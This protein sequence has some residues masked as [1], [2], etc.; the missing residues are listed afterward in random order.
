MPLFHSDR[1][2][3][4]DGAPLSRVRSSPA[5]SGYSGHFEE[6]GRFK[7]WF[8]K[9]SHKLTH[10][11]SSS[12]SDA[13]GA[14]R[15]SS[16][17]G[18]VPLARVRA[19]A[20]G[21][22]SAGS[23]DETYA[24]KM[25]SESN[26]KD[27]YS[28]KTRTARIDRN[29]LHVAFASS[30]F[31]EDPPQQIPPVHAAKGNVEFKNGELLL[32]PRPHQRS[33]F[34]S[35]PYLER[36]HEDLAVIAQ[37]RARENAI[38]LHQ[39]MT[40]R[41]SMGLFHSASD[42]AL[43]GME[44]ESYGEEALSK[45]EVNGANLASEVS[46][47]HASRRSSEVQGQAGIS[48]Q[49]DEKE[50]F[51][52]SH[53]RKAKDN[54]EVIYTRCCHL[55][56]IMPIK[57][58]IRQLKGQVAP[59]PRL[60]IINF[61]PALIEV[62]ALADFLAIVPVVYLNLDAHIF[63][64]EMVR[65]LCAALYNS[66]YMARLSFCNTELDPDAWRHLCSFLAGNKSLLHLDLSCDPSKKSKVK[67][68]S[69]AKND[70][71]AFRKAL[72]KR[73]GLDELTLDYTGIRGKDILAL[74]SEGLKNCKVLGLAHNNL[75]PSEISSVVDWV[76]HENSEC[77]GISLDGNDLS[78]SSDDVTRLFKTPRLYSISLRNTNLVVTEGID[79]ASAIKVADTSKLR[80]L[81][82]SGNREVLA[83][84]LPHLVNMLPHYK[85]LARLLLDDCNLSSD[86]I[87]LLCESVSR[88]PRLVYLSLQ[89]KSR[90]SEMACAALCVAVHSRGTIV[91]VD[92]DTSY[93]PEVYRRRLNEYLMQNLSQRKTFDDDIEIA[94]MNTR[95]IYKEIEQVTRE[96][97]TGEDN[98]VTEDVL[99][100]I[101]D[102]R[103]RVRRGLHELIAKKTNGTLAIEDRE[104][105][106]KLFYIDGSLD[107]L[108]QQCVSNAGPGTRLPLNALPT[109]LTEEK[110]SKVD[111]G[112]IRPSMSR[113]S[114][115]QSI[116]SLKKQ[117]QG[118][119]V[120]HKLYTHLCDLSCDSE[121]NKQLAKLL[122]ME[123][124]AEDLSHEELI[125]RIRQLHARD[126]K[127]IVD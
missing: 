108:F 58:I 34:V 65:L 23:A 122:S 52:P 113:M 12:G 33:N 6:Q 87:V 37:Q 99:E 89:S 90:F 17:E 83:E 100:R 49:R 24:R 5:A 127:Q 3:N 78:K 76:C 51:E 9:L 68:F 105:L 72:V 59:V 40:S 71:R 26:S 28:S 86:S 93:W 43:L 61:R 96:I 22:F 77:I 8:G 126:L 116:M 98:K 94:D 82:L 20:P 53:V 115:N 7:G 36:N 97:D 123:A 13:L 101:I 16:H 120:A 73:G 118:E 103:D 74:L 21:S 70:W 62:Q 56:E 79:D 15:R 14:G 27:S 121:R 60:Q 29:M 104:A 95:N 35:P 19:K 109:Q 111:E 38:K 45:L 80:Q 30:V 114:S 119:A 106:I 66:T 4:E 107:R 44:E 92:T 1:S 41:H 11:G 55:R 64:A 102:M 124:G 84:I 50:V 25:H 75:S 18:N 42:D 117:Q 48:D 112:G 57:S 88:C 10:S 2:A 69:R 67:S 32:G 46:S 39:L 125:E 31:E 47:A 110:V 63:T 81:D 85:H 54:P 91:T